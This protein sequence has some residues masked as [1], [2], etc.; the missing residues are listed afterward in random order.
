MGD[1]ITSSAGSPE[2]VNLSLARRLASPRGLAFTTPADWPACLVGN[3]ES[4]AARSWIEDARNNVPH[5]YSVEGHP[6]DTLSEAQELL[7]FRT[8]V[9]SAPQMVVFD[10]GRRL[11]N[12]ERERFLKTA[13]DGYMVKWGLEFPDV[14][15]LEEVWVEGVEPP[16]LDDT[17]HHFRGDM[18]LMD[19]WDIYP[20]IVLDWLSA[21]IRNGASLA[22][23]GPRRVCLTRA[24]HP[25][26]EENRLPVGEELELEM[27]ENRRPRWFSKCPFK[28]FTRVPLGRVPKWKAKLVNG[29]YTLVEAL[30]VILDYSAGYD[31]S[32][33]KLKGGVSADSLNA[34]IP[35]MD[36][37]FIS[38]DEILR[39]F[40]DAPKESWCVV[41]DFAH[42][43]Q[44]I[45]I[46]KKDWPFGMVYLEGFGWAISTRLQYGSRRSAGVWEVFGEFFIVMM[47]CRYGITGLLRWVDDVCYFGAT[48]EQCLLVQSLLV[49]VSKRYGFALH[50]VKI[51]GP[52][53]NIDFTGINWTPATKTVMFPPAKIAKYK[54]RFQVLLDSARWTIHDI[55]STHGVIMHLSK[56]LLALRFMCAEWS[57]LLASLLKPKLT[58]CR[59]PK[60]LAWHLRTLL[61]V[62]DHHSGTLV[63]FIHSK[64]AQQKECVPFVLLR[65]DASSEH[66]F[67]GYIPATHSFCKGIWTAEQKA[68]HIAGTHPS[69][70]LFEAQ[71][72]INVLWSF[73]QEIR[74][75]NVTAEVDAQV[76]EGK[77][78]S[79]YQRFGNIEK[80]NLAALALIVTECMLNICLSVVHIPGVTNTHSDLLSRGVQGWLQFQ[81]LARSE[82]WSLKNCERQA[83]SL[84]E[85]LWPLVRPL[86]W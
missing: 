25:A 81:T 76:L 78:K 43:H 86:C 77:Y 62:L 53:L 14:D 16:S 61:A 38:F 29:K 44:S 72:L 65:T 34:H 85:D 10:R 71:G 63:P 27:E 32:L 39:T 7:H 73:Q 1:V 12:H 56:I 51:Q 20:P 9:L 80:M 74:G 45:S 50:P 31:R 41:F 84:P 57:A 28:F 13:P 30:R 69:S 2:E 21:T 35:K 11:D 23:N 58:G 19:A 4:H 55:Q 5:I 52:L 46:R 37:K 66:G 26:V 75:G 68:S 22:Y 15:D 33:G 79:G 59:R 18:M 40:L 60:K 82:G 83:V 70:P 36:I 67:G 42:A 17:R 47:F 64:M 49:Y 6:E 8:H 3:N 54:L 24:N 48:Y